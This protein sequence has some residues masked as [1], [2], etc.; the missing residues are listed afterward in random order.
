MKVSDVPGVVRMPLPVVVALITLARYRGAILPVV[1]RELAVLSGR[2]ATIPD[3]DLR[4][5]ALHALTA[6]RAN[7]EATATLA[8]LAPRRGRR[9]VIRASTALQVAVDYLDTLGEAAGPSALAD[10]LQLHRS[11]E[12]ALIPGAGPLDWYAHHPRGDDGGYLDSLVATCQLAVAALPGQAALPA[13]RRA[14]ARC[15]EGQS[16][17]HAENGA[18]LEA[19]ASTLPPLPGL[20]WW[21]AAAGASSSVGTHALLAL[22]GDPAARAAEA[23]L[24]AAAY[25]PWIGALTVLLDD[26]VDRELDERN[27]DHNYLGY[28]GEE[29]PA[30]ID[31]LVAGGRRALRDAP[32]RGVHEAILNGV[33]AY[34]L[35][36]S[37]GSPDGRPS[38]ADDAPV[39]TLVAAI[40]LAR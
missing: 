26:F 6:K 24:V 38:M 37:W 34:Y 8:T 23:E 7:V 20:S 30:R 32:R 3:P 5:S 36:N 27:G 13:A 14:I 25:D 4:R 35:G 31:F 2:A 21:E 28:Y 15:G 11:L 18:G 19:W 12:I 22:A 9:A 10:G 1:D 33:L 16:H 39:R 29:A 40:R 17:T